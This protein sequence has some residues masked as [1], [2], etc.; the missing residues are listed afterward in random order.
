MRRAPV[1]ALFLFT[2]RRMTPARQTLSMGPALRALRLAAVVGP[3][4]RHGDSDTVD[5]IMTED[6]WQGGQPRGLAPG[7]LAAHRRRS[8]SNSSP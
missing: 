2:A 5:A 4:N 6:T 1:R 7:N 8:S 3:L